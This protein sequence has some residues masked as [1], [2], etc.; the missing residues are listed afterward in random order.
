MKKRFSNFPDMNYKTALAQKY[1]DILNKTQ[2]IDVF[3]IY[4][5]NYYHLIY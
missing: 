3:N 1:Q 4:I 5:R 2:N